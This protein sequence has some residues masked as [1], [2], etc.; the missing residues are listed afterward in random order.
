MLKNGR[1]KLGTPG[2]DLAWSKHVIKTVSSRVIINV[3]QTL[4]G[5]EWAPSVVVIIDADERVD[6][7]LLTK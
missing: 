7:S 3:T 6:C 4:A 5:L 1:A 2:P